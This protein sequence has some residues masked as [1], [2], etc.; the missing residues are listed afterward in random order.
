[1]KLQTK[2]K[3]RSFNFVLSDVDYK[4]LH[5]L[6]NDLNMKPSEYLRTLIQVTWL[7]NNS[8]KVLKNGSLEIGGYGITF[9]TE[10]LET[11]TN[12]LENAFSDLNWNELE[13]KI[14]ITGQRH[15]RPK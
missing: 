5:T 1:M 9:P 12:K 13:D 11:F 3:S 15:Y 14:T 2:K 4:N 6:A 7:A 8:D 10:F